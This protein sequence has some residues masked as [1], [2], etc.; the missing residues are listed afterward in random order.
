MKLYLK[1]I[2]K[3]KQAS[4]ELNGITVIAGENNTGK[5]TIGR[6]L[7]ALFRSFFHIDRRIEEERINSIVNILKEPFKGSI[8]S[9][10]RKPIDFISIAQNIILSKEKYKND[11]FLLKQDLIKFILDSVNMFPNELEFFLSKY[12]VFSKIQISLR[13]SDTDLLKLFLKKSLS[14]EFNGQFSNIFIEDSCEIKFWIKDKS[15]T[16]SIENNDIVT[17]EN[18]DALSL[19]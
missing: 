12:D 7:F 6:T 11:E 18:T 10:Y 14:A 15:I 17:I 9:L 4:V 1:N 8:S 2:G 5:S 13:I 19:Y 3:V 16:I